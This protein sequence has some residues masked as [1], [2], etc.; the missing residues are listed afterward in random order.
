MKDLVASFRGFLTPP[1]SASWQTLML[2]SLFSVFIAFFLT[3]FPQGFVSFWGWFFLITAV[4]WFVYQKDVKNALTFNGIFSKI[5]VG[6]WIVSTLICVAVFGS[7]VDFAKLGSITPPMFICIPPLAALIDIAPQFIKTN[8]VSKTP[9]FTLPKT[10][11]RQG[12]VLF[13]LSHFL[14]ACWI[15]F[16]FLLQG[17]LGMYPSI[18]SDDFSRSSFV[19]R[20]PQASFQASRGREVLNAAEN[21]LRDRFNNQTWSETERWLFETKGN[22]W[23]KDLQGSVQN[24]LKGKL[25]SG[26]AELWQL[27]AKVA[28]DTYDSGALYNLGLEATWTGPSADGKN[29]KV[30]KNCEIIPKRVFSRRAN[31]TIPDTKMVGKLSCTDVNEPKLKKV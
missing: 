17:W 20:G 25:G 26:E 15:Q 14:I 22:A 2:L 21:E 13:V 6:P 12:I 28:G 30:T 9:E 1:Q 3:P 7:W 24:R 27:G 19:V 11:K 29:H 10:G 4:W 18:L 16:Y 5:F 8:P 23:V 31:S